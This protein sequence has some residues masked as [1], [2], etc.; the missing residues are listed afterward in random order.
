MLQKKLKKI[1]RKEKQFGAKTAGA[2]K[3]SAEMTQCRTGKRPN[4]GAEVGAPEWRHRNFDAHT[5]PSPPEHSLLFS[6]QR[7]CR[8]AEE[9][10]GSDHRPLWVENE[11]KIP[12]ASTAAEK[13]DEDV[14]SAS[15]QDHLF[16]KPSSMNLLKRGDS[17]Q[18]PIK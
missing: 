1:K 18:P 11:G 9:D 13:E 12:T 6:Q 5:Q 17:L 2:E 7:E 3:A 4:G 16:K 14:I 8:S 15:N 10:N